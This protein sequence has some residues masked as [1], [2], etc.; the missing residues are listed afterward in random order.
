MLC[1]CV[2]TVRQKAKEIVGFVQD[3]ERL[4]EARKQAKQT[5]DKYVGYSSEEATS[6]YS[7]LVLFITSSNKDS[8]LSLSLSLP[9]YLPPLQVTAMLQSLDLDPPSCQ[10]GRPHTTMRTH[11]GRS[12]NTTMK[13]TQRRMAIRMMLVMSTELPHRGKPTISVEFVTHLYTTISGNFKFWTD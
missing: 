10:V 13:R 7:K 9:A 2:Y 3:E 8:A 12:V 6:R 11:E 1:L 5:R 4:R